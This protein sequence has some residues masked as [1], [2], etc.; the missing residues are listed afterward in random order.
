M[1]LASL[2]PFRSRLFVRPAPWVWRVFA[3]LGMLYMMMLT[4]FLY[5]KTED[6][7]QVLKNIDS[8]M[9]FTP[10]SQTIAHSKLWN[11]LHLKEFVKN[12]I[13]WIHSRGLFTQTIHW[14]IAAFIYRDY[15]VLWTIL[16]LVEVAKLLIEELYPI[17]FEPYLERIVLNVFVCG[18]LGIYEGMAAIRRLSIQR[19]DWSGESLPRDATVSLEVMDTKQHS[20]RDSVSVRGDPLPHFVNSHNT[21]CPPDSSQT[22]PLI[23]IPQMIPLTSLHA[24]EDNVPADLFWSDKG[25]SMMARQRRKMISHRQKQERRSKGQEESYIDGDVSESE[26]WSQREDGIAEMSEDDSRSSGI[27]SFLYNLVV[28]TFNR[29]KQPK[30][31]GNRNKNDVN[32]TPITA[33]VSTAIDV[34]ESPSLTPMRT[35]ESYFQMHQRIASHHDSDSE[36]NSSPLQIPSSQTPSRPESAVLHSQH[37]IDVPCDLPEHFISPPPI[38]PQKPNIPLLAPQPT[39]VS[40]FRSPSDSLPPLPSLS[41]PYHG[42]SQVTPS[43]FPTPQMSFSYSHRPRSVISSNSISPSPLTPPIDTSHQFKSRKQRTRKAPAVPGRRRVMSISQYNTIVQNRYRVHEIDSASFVAL[44]GVR[45]GEGSDEH[46]KDTSQSVY[47]GVGKKEAV[48]VNGLATDLKMTSDQ[49][50]ASS[51]K[52]QTDQLDLLTG[53]SSSPNTHHPFAFTRLRSAFVQWMTPWNVT[54]YRWN[55][56]KQPWRLVHVVLI[57]SY[58]VV[59]ALVTELFCLLLPITATHPIMIARELLTLV[60]GMPTVGE[61]Y[62]YSALRTSHIGSFA[63][64]AFMITALE[65]ILIQHFLPP[66]NTPLPKSITILLCLCGVACGFFGFYHHK[67]PFFIRAQN[68]IRYS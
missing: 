29:I 53:L 48:E 2:D 60:V 7:Q 26:E 13:S 27:A 10:F 51:A 44:D 66:L 6:I 59:S 4:F 58:G 45:N 17:T 34:L 31:R 21:P 37:Q 57:M 41:S 68:S 5:Q 33:D 18:A 14:Y 11:G 35:S 1:T 25:D 12:P 40:H 61:M 20:D 47:S 52:G 63:W 42:G 39:V 19:M 9:N 46:I 28:G 3:G 67:K 62:R 49:T 36:H 24:L 56:M 38:Q 22:P 15:T 54:M 23:R 30:K 8:S 50:I 65:V 43:S 64:M 16:G 32:F 55:V